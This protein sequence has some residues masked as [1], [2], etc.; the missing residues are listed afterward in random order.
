MDKYIRDINKGDVIR[1]QVD[2]HRRDFKV[3]RK[4]SIPPNPGGRRIALDLADEQT[5]KVMYI[6]RG[7]FAV[8]QVIKEAPC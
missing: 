7:Q 4:E 8:I 6:E 3:I 2:D 1:L 5:H